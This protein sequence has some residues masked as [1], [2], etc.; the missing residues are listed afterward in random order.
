M[1]TLI[2][3]CLASFAT[4]AL[5][6]E[7]S[8][9]PEQYTYGTKL[10]IAKVISVSEVPQVCEVVPAKMIYEDHQGQRHV[11]EYHVMGDGCS[12]H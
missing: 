2:A 1:K 11:L 5:A 12:L 8:P 3:M 7:T 6:N 10:D 9:T 4:V